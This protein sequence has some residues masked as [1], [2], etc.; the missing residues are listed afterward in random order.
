MTAQNQIHFRVGLLG[1]DPFFQSKQIKIKWKQKRLSIII[2]KKASPLIC[3]KAECWNTNPV[4]RR[5]SG[6]FL[7]PRAWSPHGTCSS[8]QVK[9]VCVCVCAR[10]CLS[11]CTLRWS[12]EEAFPPAKIHTQPGIKRAETYQQVLTAL[13][14]SLDQI[15][16]HSRFIFP[17]FICPTNSRRIHQ[18]YIL[19]FLLHREYIM[20]SCIF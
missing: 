9:V 6:D 12:S 2:T 8:A 10:L 15:H 20:K 11:Y 13:P 5:K 1:L 18:A 14:Q 3:F 7:G 19:I 16:H 17:L 4:L